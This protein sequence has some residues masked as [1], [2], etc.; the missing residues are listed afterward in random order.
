[1]VDLRAE[2]PSVGVHRHRHRQPVH[3]GRVRGHQALAAVLDP[4]DG[5]TQV[6]GREQHG[7]LVAP[8][9]HLLA[10]RP[11]HVAHVDPHLVLADPEDAGRGERQLVGALSR[12]PHVEAPGVTLP[13]G[14]QAPGL[15]GHVALPLLMERLGHH[16]VGR[17]E[18]LIQLGVRTGAGRAQ[19]GAQLGMD[20]MGTAGGLLVVD[21]RSQRLVLDVYELE[22]VLGEVAVLGHDQGHRVAHEADIAGGQD[23]GRDDGRL[24]R[25]DRGPQRVDMAVQVLGGQHRVHAGRAG[26]RRGVQAPDAGPGEVASQERSVEHSRQAN[27]VDV[28]TGARNQAAVLDPL[29]GLAHEPPGRLRGLHPGDSRRARRSGTRS[30]GSTTVRVRACAA[31]C[32]T[33]AMMP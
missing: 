18:H 29:D 23:M 16:E 24:R 11:A 9:V 32:W 28:L 1:M 17:L 22:G 8:R 31:A 27:V 10:E 33:A 7:H 30:H 5:P 2:D 12:R 13:V 21:D 6:A 26:G 3:P 25:I 15:H 4:F 19:V 20:Q 14:D